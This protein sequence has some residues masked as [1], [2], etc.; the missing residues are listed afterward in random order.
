V[1]ESAMWF[2]C[3]AHLALSDQEDSSV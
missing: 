3:A 1:Y 2:L